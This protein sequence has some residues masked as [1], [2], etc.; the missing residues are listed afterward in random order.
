[1]K[2]DALYDTG[3][4][5]KNFETYKKDGLYFFIV[6]PIIFVLMVLTY[7]AA[8]QLSSKNSRICTYLGR[9][10]LAGTPGDPA[11]LKG[12]YTYEQLAQ[13]GVL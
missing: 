7:L 1:M 3:M 10:W 5:K 8:V 9:M 11:S 2:T 13:K 4:A 12:C 6:L